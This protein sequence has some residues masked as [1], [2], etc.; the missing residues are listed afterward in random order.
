MLAVGLT[1]HAV[2]LRD[3]RRFGRA[4]FTRQTN[5][6]RDRHA[7]NLR[8]PARRLGQTVLAVAEDVVLVIALRRGAGR[9]G[10]FVVADAVLVKESLIDQILGNQH[11]GE[12]FAQRGIGTRTDRHPFIF[13][14][15]HRVGVHRVDQNGAHGTAILR[16]LP[17]VALAAAGEAGIQRTVAKGEIE[18]AI[19]HF[20]HVTAVAASPVGVRHAFTNLSAR[21]GAVLVEI[22]PQHVQQAEIRRPPDDQLIGTRAIL[23]ING[24]VAVLR[25]DPLERGGD[26]IKG[27]VPAD[28]L[29]LALTAL[30]DALH[31]VFQALGAVEA[32]AH[33]APPY[34]GPDMGRT[35]TVRTDIFRLDAN[36]FAILDDNFQRT[37]A[38]AVDDAGTQADSEKATNRPTAWGEKN[39][40]PNQKLG[41][42]CCLCF[43]PWCTA[44]AQSGTGCRRIEQTGG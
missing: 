1:L 33:R 35:A 28:A 30:A 29:E 32:L 4:D 3:E 24:L 5:N 7:G 14:A 40:L 37:A 38:T 19:H 27:L 44:F 41:F 11:V 17:F 39:V 43:V 12:T 25:D 15:E 31:R 21:I 18:L 10:L 23:V 26:R 6:R 16:T 36:D 8:G 42:R 13:L 34:T 22:T 2:A 20:G 9:Q